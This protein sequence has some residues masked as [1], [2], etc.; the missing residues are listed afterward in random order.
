[1]NLT[2]QQPNSIQISIYTINMLLIDEETYPRDFWDEIDVEIAVA[3]RWWS[4]ERER[5]WRGFEVD[6]CLELEPGR[7]KTIH[8]RGAGSNVKVPQTVNKTKIIG[9][10]YSSVMSD[11]FIEHMELLHL[12]LSWRQKASNFL[13]SCSALRSLS[14][15]LATDF[16]QW[17]ACFTNM[18]YCMYTNILHKPL[19]DKKDN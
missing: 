2:E 9:Y 7:S 19:I 4:R 11:W 1:M 3:S 6:G 15:F 18:K 8:R 12:I 5:D 16:Q 13:S 14:S 10:Q 17:R